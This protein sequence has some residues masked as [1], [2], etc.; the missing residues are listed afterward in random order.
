MP[1]FW[2]KAMNQ[3][4]IFEIWAPTESLWSPWVKPV[5]FASMHAAQ[6]RTELDCRNDL[7][8]APAP[9]DTVLVVDLPGAEGVTA[10]LALAARGYR[11]IPLYNA[12]PRPLMDEEAGQVAVDVRLIMSV[13]YH[14]SPVLVKAGLA[15]DAPPAFLLDARR[16]GGLVDV[17]PGWFDNRSVS[18]TTDFPSANFLM[19]HGFRRVLLIQHEAS[20][21]QPDLAHTLRNWQEGGL[22][23]E[24]F[25]PGRDA[26]IMP[27][28]VERPSRFRR[29]WQRAL[30]MLGFA[31]NELGGF[32]GMLADSS[33]G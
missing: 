20:Q 19:A 12:V 13:L 23:I 14:G 7:S 31:R 30:E 28:A 27:C 8:L 17:Q 4:S 11:P 26:Q 21:P 33:G 3:E 10:G 2:C 32:G 24:L 22:V 5:L 16:R 18:F 9:N 25:R 1:P 6:S 15:P 29:V